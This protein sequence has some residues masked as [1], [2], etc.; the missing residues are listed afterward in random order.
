MNLESFIETLNQRCLNSQLKLVMVRAYEG[1]PATKVGNDIDLIINENSVQKWLDIIKSICDKQQLKFDVT[2]IYSYC[3]K[4]VIYG[5]EDEVNGLEIDLNNS[6]CWKGVSFFDIDEYI[7]DSTPVNEVI[8][9]CDKV[10]NCYITFCHGYLYGGVVSVKYLPS[11]KKIIGDPLLNSEM[12][13]LLNRVFTRKQS[14]FLLNLLELGDINKLRRKSTI[15]RIT[16]L[17]RW[18]ARHPIL[19]IKNL[20]SSY[21]Y[22]KVIKNYLAS[23]NYSFK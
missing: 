22:P 11:Y 3:T 10:V 18:A 21:S 1:L 17:L 6:F 12:K 13:I 7:S 9:S 2:D 8:L 20:S 4:T 15:F 19:F 5:I 16:V 23:V 14:D